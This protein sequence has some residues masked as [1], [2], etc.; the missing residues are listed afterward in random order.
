MSKTS[1]QNGIVIIN[2]MQPISV[3]FSVSQEY[4]PKLIEKKYLKNNPL[5]VLAIDKDNKETLSIGK[6]NSICNQVDTSTG[7]IRLRAEFNN[8]KLN[9]FLTNL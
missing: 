1:D 9:L 8:D 6:L 3:L 2:K 7:T 5:Q 4:L